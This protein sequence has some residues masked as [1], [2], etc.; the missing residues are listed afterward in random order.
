MT[1]YNLYTYLLFCGAL[2]YANCTPCAKTRQGL[3]RPLT[4]QV[5][6]MQLNLEE[7]K[8]PFSKLSATEDT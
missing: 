2:I 6:E 1:V 7:S 3:K 5:W 8:P 4:Y